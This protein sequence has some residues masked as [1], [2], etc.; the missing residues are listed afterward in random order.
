MDYLGNGRTRT[1]QTGPDGTQSIQEFQS[2]RSLSTTVSNATLGILQ[3]QTTGYDAHNR[4]SSVTDLRTGT[5]SFTFDNLDRVLT[6]TTPAPAAGESAQVTTSVYDAAGRVMRT[7]APDGL[8]TTNEYYLTG[9]YLIRN[10]N[11]QHG[12]CHL[13]DL[14]PET[15]SWSPRPCN[16]GRCAITYIHR[17]AS[18]Q[19]PPTSSAVQVNQEEISSVKLQAVGD[20][21][22]A[23]GD[24][25]ATKLS[26]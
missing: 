8:W 14:A 4:P 12:E 25:L 2:G 5:T 15:A 11:Q 9:L 26:C 3:Q 7:Q 1:T 17:N 23:V 16:Q 22:T 19:G 10:G 13:F 6:V 20:M 24:S 21:F 18:T